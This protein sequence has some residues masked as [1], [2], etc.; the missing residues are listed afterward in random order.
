LVG[1]SQKKKIHIGVKHD[2]EHDV[3]PSEEDLR[4]VACGLG[5]GGWGWGPLMRFNE[6]RTE[7]LFQINADNFLGK[8]LTINFK[9]LKNTLC[10]VFK[11]L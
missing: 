6:C 10:N 11:W 7:P 4:Q 5:S 2:W 9:L 3:V 8:Q 1:K